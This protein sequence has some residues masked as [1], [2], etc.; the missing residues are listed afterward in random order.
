MLAATSQDQL[1]A[2]FTHDAGENF[3]SGQ[4]DQPLFATPIRAP[5]PAS[6][7]TAGTQPAEN[8]A[9]TVASAPIDSATAS[10]IAEY[11]QLTSESLSLDR[12]GDAVSYFYAAALAG[13]D[14]GAWSQQ[15]K[16]VPAVRRP[17]PSSASASGCSTKGPSW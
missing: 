3:T 1:R 4:V 9:P 10:L 16:W 11:T 7:Q 2:M 14:G 6:T 8:S 12:E 13:P 15:Y 17:R 5:Q